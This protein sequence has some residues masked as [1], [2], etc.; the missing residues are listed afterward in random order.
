[1]LRAKW[2]PPEMEIQLT[3]GAGER[4]GDYVHNLLYTSDVFVN[5]ATG[6]RDAQRA[7]QL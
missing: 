3:L 6:N 2:S 7:S 1:M 5:R 4:G